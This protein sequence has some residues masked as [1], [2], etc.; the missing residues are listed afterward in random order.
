MNHD[1]IPIFRY[2]SVKYNDCMEHVKNSST[3]VCVGDCYH[4]HY[5]NKDKDLVRSKMLHQILRSYATREN[6]PLYNRANDII[7]RI[8]QAGLIKK[9]EDEVLWEVKR[10]EERKNS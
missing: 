6:W 4:L 7:H 5:T 8:M 2:K 10:E 9:I 3:A 1:L